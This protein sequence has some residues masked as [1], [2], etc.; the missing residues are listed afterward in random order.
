MATF[1]SKINMPR[2]EITRLK[3]VML[4]FIQQDPR[5]F[6]WAILQLAPWERFLNRPVVRIGIYD[7]VWIGV[8]A[9]I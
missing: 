3:V 2:T 9:V 5:G 1:V 8:E 4:A 6:A 7:L